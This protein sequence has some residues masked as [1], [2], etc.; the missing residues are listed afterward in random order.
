MTVFAE[1]NGGKIIEFESMPAVFVSKE[2]PF[3][4]VLADSYESVTGIENEF[5]LAYGGSNITAKQ[6]NS[7]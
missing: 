7:P 3:L 4:Q 1:A 6:Y 2:R 5:T